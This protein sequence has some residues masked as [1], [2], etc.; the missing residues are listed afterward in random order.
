ML[1]ALGPNFGTSFQLTWAVL[2]HALG[3]FILLTVG[4]VLAIVVVGFILHFIQKQVINSAYG[5]AQ[6]E[7]TDRY[8]NDRLGGDKY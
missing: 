4:I 7:D 5:S 1:S 6:A 8:W 2:G 3:P